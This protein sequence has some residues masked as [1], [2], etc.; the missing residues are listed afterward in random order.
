MKRDET[1]KAAIDAASSAIEHRDWCD[2]NHGD[3]CDCSALDVDGVTTAVDAV[4]SAVADDLATYR[5]SLESTEPDQGYLA[6]LWEAADHIRSL[7]EEGKSNDDR[8]R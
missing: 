3:S 5:E 6:G 8:E 2:T 1:L 7:I 4:L